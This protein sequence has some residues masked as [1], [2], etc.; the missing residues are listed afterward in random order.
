MGGKNKVSYEEKQNSQPQ[1]ENNLPFLEMLGH[2][3]VSCV[4]ECTFGHSL[5][6]QGYPEKWIWTQVQEY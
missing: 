2:C 4:L 6:T 5:E 1:Q 3:L